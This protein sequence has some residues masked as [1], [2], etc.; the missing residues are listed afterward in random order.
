MGIAVMIADLYSNPPPILQH[1]AFVTGII[2]GAGI[3]FAVAY[4]IH[5]TTTAAKPQPT[6]G[7]KACP[8]CGAEYPSNAVECPND[9]T[10]LV[11]R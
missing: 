1:I 6:K 3:V 5:K 11:P 4:K 2:I 9:Q 10:Y 7:I 8:Y